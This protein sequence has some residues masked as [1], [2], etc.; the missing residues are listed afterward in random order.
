MKRRVIVIRRVGRVLHQALELRVLAIGEFGG[1]AGT[2][3]I[4]SCFD[5]CWPQPRRS[6]IESCK[7][8]EF[9]KEIDE[10]G[11]SLTNGVGPSIGLDHREELL[12]MP[13]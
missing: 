12:Q 1:R 7:Y 5:L 11:R 10:F 6:F 9:P 2:A 8:L 13:R 3:W 4:R